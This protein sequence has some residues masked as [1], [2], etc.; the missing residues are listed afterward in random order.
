M[1]TICLL[2]AAGS[3]SRMGKP[4]MLLP[5]KEKTLLQHAVDEIKNSDVDGLVVVTGCYHSLLKKILQ[6]LQI[7]FI[8]NKNWEEGMGSSI[9]QGI[10][11]IVR[12]YP[13]ANNV[14]ITVCDQPYL[15]SALLNE[16]Q[17]S[18][19]QTGKGIIASA[20]NDT[21]GTPVLFA[22]KYFEHLT[23][24]SG[25]HGAKKILQSFSGD[26]E[27]VNFSLGFFDIDTP[28]DYDRLNSI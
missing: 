8:E 3:S 20:Y 25:E 7:D 23:A 2:L 24:L 17:N 21:I 4:K 5:F 13:E 11:Y 28:Q 26:V 14:I 1:I 9:Q 12:Q 19:M 18:A 16:L 27:T 6:P 10:Q 15:S 22:K